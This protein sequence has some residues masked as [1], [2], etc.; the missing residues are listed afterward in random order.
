MLLLVATER[1]VF[2][3]DP[4][5]GTVTAARGLDD[6]PTCL[7]AD[8]LTGGRAWCGTRRRGVFRSDDGGATWRPAELEGRALMSLAASPTEPDVLW[9]APSRARCGA[10]RKTAGSTAVSALRRGNG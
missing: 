1:D 8:P 10:R 3:I 6:H 4:D 5:R 2:M 9:A 7:A